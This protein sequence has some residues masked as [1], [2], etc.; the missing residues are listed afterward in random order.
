MGHFDP[1]LAAHARELIAAKN[2]APLLAIVT[3]S[4]TPL[5]GCR[6]RAELVAAV[7]AV[8]YVLPLPE[9]LPEAECRKLRVRDMREQDRRRGK[10]LEEHVRSRHA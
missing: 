4:E 9:G 7:G 5:L 1:L 10:E 2:G 3:D 8:D 6:A